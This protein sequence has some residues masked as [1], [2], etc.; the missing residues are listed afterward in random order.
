MADLP[1]DTLAS[2]RQEFLAFYSVASKADALLM[3]ELIGAFTVLV[4]AIQQPRNPEDPLRDQLEKVTDKADQSFA[5]AR[6][7]VRR[8][9]TFKALCE[10]DRRRIESV[11]FSPY[12]EWER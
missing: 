11:L 8:C 9:G 12:P 2:A 6:E 3:D 5:A 7:A 4:V 10:G 1:N